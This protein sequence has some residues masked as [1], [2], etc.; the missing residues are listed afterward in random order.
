MGKDLAFGVTALL[1]STFCVV[2]LVFSIR[3]ASLALIA[4][5]FHNI[6]DV[7]SIAVA[8]HAHRTSQRKKSADDAYTFAYRRSELLGGFFN[9]S[10]LVSLCLYVVLE[11]IP[12]FIT[13]PSVAD[14]T[15]AY[16][17]EFMGIAAAGV[18]MNLVCA[19]IFG[20]AGIAAHGGH[21]HG[22]GH[23]H[24]HHHDD[25]HSSE[26]LI[27]ESSRLLDTADDGAPKR[28]LARLDVNILA[29]L[30]HMV[31]DV[32]SSLVVL[33]M[34]L[35][36]YFEGSKPWT[37]YVDPAA[38]LLIV[39]IILATTIPAFSRITGVLMQKSPIQPALL[40]REL[41]KV[42]GVQ[43]IHE[44]HVWSLVDG[45]N[46]GTAHVVCANNA[47]AQVRAE[48]RGVFH[49]FGVH[50]VTVQTEPADV[51]AAGAAGAVAAGGGDE[52][53]QTHCVD[54][55]EAKKCCE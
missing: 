52:S 1:T 46:I 42:S 35:V 13:P 22:H 34:G 11:A 41:R 55:C 40:Q 12:R 19:L 9:L 33:A 17:V 27:N 6:S 21:S 47:A 28:R 36:I 32:L 39:A 2:E 31:G 23:G 43:Q 45:T 4:D 16:S 14:L 44:L 54:G 7:I 25:A 20:V 3:L 8:W 29:L 18:G 15:T 50:S 10:S 5:A 37:A 48:L 51:S 26:A 49:K 24:A 38:S 53:C 30:I